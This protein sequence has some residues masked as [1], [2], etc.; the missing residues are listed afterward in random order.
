MLV[1]TQI[2]YFAL[3]V[4]YQ[5]LRTPYLLYNALPCLG[6]TTWPYKCV[7]SM[8]NRQCPAPYKS[9]INN[10]AFYRQMSVFSKPVSKVSM[11]LRSVVKL[12]RRVSKADVVAKAASSAVYQWHQSGATVPKVEA[13]VTVRSMIPPSKLIAWTLQ[14]PL[15]VAAKISRTWNVIR[16]NWRIIRC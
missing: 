14:R 10:C 7:N 3:N 13:G 2:S 4:S 9:L 15:W 11:W 12:R 6:A 8:Y 1:G 16:T 5:L